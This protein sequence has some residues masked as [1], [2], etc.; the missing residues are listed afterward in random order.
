MSVFTELCKRLYISWAGIEGG[1][2][3][4]EKT[5]LS[6]SWPVFPSTEGVGA[7]ISSSSGLIS[8]EGSASFNLVR[9]MVGDGVGRM[10]LGDYRVIIRGECIGR[11]HRTV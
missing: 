1:L 5:T 10:M 11:S 9:C 2:D 7:A 8:V 4:G 6:P 3:L